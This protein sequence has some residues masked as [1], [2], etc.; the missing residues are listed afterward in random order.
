MVKVKQNLKKVFIFGTPFLIIPLLLFLGCAREVSWVYL[1]PKSVELN[2]LDE[3]FQIKAAALDKENKPVPG[4][5]LNWESSSPEAAVVDS[6]GLVTAKGSGNTIITATAEA[7]RKTMDEDEATVFTQTLS[8]QRELLA[9]LKSSK[10]TGR[11]VINMDAVLLI[12]SSELNLEVR[13]GDR[14]VVMKRPDSIN[15]LG[16]V[17]NPTALFAEKEKTVDYYLDLVGGPTKQANEKAISDSVRD[18]LK[19]ALDSFAAAFA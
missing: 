19:A 5:V 14:L 3:T 1:E 11:M 7:T 2:K 16:E 6:N 12:P 15:I 4:A 17:Y 8:A 9:K 10:P 18:S 13:P